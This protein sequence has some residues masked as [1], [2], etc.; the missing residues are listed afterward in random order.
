MTGQKMVAI[1]IIAIAALAN[2]RV[3]AEGDAT[4]GEKVFS[5]C[6]VCHATVEGKN[7]IGPS[8]HA[9]VGRKAGTAAG[10][11]YSDAMTNSNIT[12]DEK[13]LDAYLKDP[14]VA[15]PGNKMTFAGV[16]KDDDRADVIA[17]LKSLSP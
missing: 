4:K 13:T 6:K 2:Q 9:V 17:Y 15:V 7:T 14:K 10:F 5:Q 1:G 12:W 16:K 11:R 8:L 3:L